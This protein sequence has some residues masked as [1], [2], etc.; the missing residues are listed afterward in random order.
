MKLIL[1][2]YYC[3]LQPIEGVWSVVKGEVA[4]LGLLRRVLK[5]AKEYFESDENIQFTVDE[6]DAYSYFDDDYVI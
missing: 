2:P 1:P 6:F 4:C 3:E 5:N